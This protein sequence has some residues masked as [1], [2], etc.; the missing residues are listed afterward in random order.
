MNPYR[1]RL[2]GL[3][4]HVRRH[5]RLR[6]ELAA[7]DR[8]VERL[9]ARL[10]KLDARLDKLVRSVERVAPRWGAGASPGR[11]DYP[12]AE[13]WLTA[14]SKQALKRKTACT[15][16]P[17]TVEWIERAIRPGDVLYDI[18]AN[19]GAY[20][21]VAAKQAAGDLRV[22]AFEPSYSTYATL[23]E[24]VVLNDAARV[25]KP[26]QVLLGSRTEIAEL[27][28]PDRQ[29]GA[30]L[31]GRPEGEGAR[32]R[33]QDGYGQ[34]VLAYRLDDLV[35]EGLAAPS[36]VKL[37]VDGAEL[38]VLEGAPETLAGTALR[39]LMI[40]VAEAEARAIAALLEP[41]GFREA[42]RHKELQDPATGGSYWY[43]LFVR[44]HV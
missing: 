14:S 6:E 38:S 40:E 7:L 9:D 11:L 42:A 29:A 41:H 24:N 12:R 35:R 44:G 22:I 33:E 1:D 10:E 3:A 15:K 30:A 36:H 34:P 28:L 39:S 31:H 21:L 32:E 16:E 2:A 4:G 19:V 27:Y 13:I 25:I 17:F 23:C 8:R 43:A 26:L 20:S 18:G 37:D 5:S